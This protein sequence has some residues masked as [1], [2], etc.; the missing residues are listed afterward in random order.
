MKYDQLIQLY[1]ERSNALQWY[2]TLYVVVIGGLLAISNLRLRRD[3]LTVCLV[4]VLYGFF[5]CKN[6]GAIHD[7]TMQRSA[8]LEAI[9]RYPTSDL[10]LPTKTVRELLEPTLV[11][12]SYDGIRNFHVGCD[13]LV[14]FLLW[15]MERR[16]VKYAKDA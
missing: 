12:P 11:Q 1:F 16:R 14:I 5:A 10:D 9:H 6:L 15:A 8:T 13:L 4:T 7:A 2:W 3:L